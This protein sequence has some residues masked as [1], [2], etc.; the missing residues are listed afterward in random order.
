MQATSPLSTTALYRKPLRVPKLLRRAWHENA[1]LT[2]TGLAMLPIIL[3]AVIGLIVDHQLITGVPAWIKP[4]KF[5][6]SI[7]IYCLTFVY[8][9][10]FVRG[11][12]RLVGAVG[13]ITGISLFVE[14][15]LV[16]LQVVR[17]TTS[18]FNLSTPLDSLI[19][20]LM[21]GSIGFL[22]TAAIVLAVVLLRQRL[23]D[24][25]WDWALRFSV[26]AAIVGMAVA[27]L[28]LIPTPAQLATSS[29]ASM[30]AHSVGVPDG[31]P[32]L[33]ILGWSTV[34]GD[35]RIPHFV[36]LHG[37]QALL[38]VGWLV[39]MTRSW[40]SMRQRTLLVIIAGCSYLSLIALLTWQAL[41]GQ[42]IIHPDVLTLSA[43]G[44]LSV[45]TLVA[46]V[47]AM[48]HKANVQPLK[49]VA[50]STYQRLLEE[51]RF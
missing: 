33:P 48:M 29:A 13:M 41:R 46:I 47:L 7:S 51:T 32:G 23:A 25:A 22:F 30:G 5:A 16:M 36:G 39:N 50:V 21:G 38:I 43:F 1:A 40:L 20:R 10:T 15:G 3:S 49:E 26:S 2:L 14:M 42:S 19:F 8:L 17:G 34:G 4:L 6:I 24:H 12:R 44:I 28:M 11:H 45:S 18:H 31:G 37:L 9:L 27:C 35:L